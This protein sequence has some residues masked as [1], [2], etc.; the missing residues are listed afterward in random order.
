MIKETVFRIANKC[1]VLSNK[2]PRAEWKGTETNRSLTVTIHASRY[3]VSFQAALANPPY[4]R[5]I[6]E[7]GLLEL[8]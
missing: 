1:T 5:Y 3:P 6:S 4:P 2:K 7:E 8:N